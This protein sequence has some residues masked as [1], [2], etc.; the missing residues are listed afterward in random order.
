MCML[1]G[2]IGTLITLI[3]LALAVHHYID[4]S[5]LTNY[6]VKNTQGGYTV[7]F[8][9]E[10][11]DS[12]TYLSIITT[13]YATIITILVTLLGAVAALAIFAIKGASLEKTEEVA[14]KEVRRFFGKSSTDDRIKGFLKGIVKS[15]IDEKFAELDTR[16]TKIGEI[17]EENDLS[18][19]LEVEDDK[20]TD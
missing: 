13:F 7:Y 19:N 15:E 8:F 3:I 5:F 9:D 2:V 17:L 12:E 4:P 6:L 20:K 18:Y 1:L 16:V 14:E 11:W 10:V